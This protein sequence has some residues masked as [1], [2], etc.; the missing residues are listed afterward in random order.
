MDIAQGLRISDLPVPPTGDEIAESFGLPVFTLA[1]QPAL[2]EAGFGTVGSNDGTHEVAI[3]YSMFRNPQDHEDPANFAPNVAETLA[4]I[5][6]AETAGQPAWFT[7]LL[8]RSRFPILW[9]AVCTARTD[10]GAPL[11][12]AERLA[13]HVNHVVMNSC[14]HRRHPEQS[15]PSTLL[16]PVSGSD[17]LPGRLIRVDAA[18]VSAIQIDTD[19]DVTG[20]AFETAQVAVLVVIPREFLP[21]VEFRLERRSPTGA[22][23]PLT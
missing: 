13:A 14:P 23:A 22:A 7:T 6:A 8:R 17:A 19:G 12:L 20:W 2:A 11:T 9:E 1:P 5:T 15:F 21:L 10:I 18:D 16:N 4:A 3:S